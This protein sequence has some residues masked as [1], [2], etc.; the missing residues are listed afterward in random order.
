[1]III[2]FLSVARKS[3]ASV[4]AAKAEDLLRRRVLAGGGGRLEI[5][6]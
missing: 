5:S 4:G 1:V 6:Q 2:V 3:Y